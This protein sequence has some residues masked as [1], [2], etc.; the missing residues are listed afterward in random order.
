MNSTSTYIN[1]NFLKNLKIEVLIQ[2]FV[3]CKNHLQSVSYTPQNYQWKKK[4]KKSE[5]KNKKNIGTSIIYCLKCT[6]KVLRYFI[7]E[8]KNLKFHI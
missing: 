1:L 2:L 5:K 7:Y 8:N 4:K 6:I 3:T